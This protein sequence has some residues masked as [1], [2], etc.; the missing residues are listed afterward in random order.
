[1]S[2]TW[3]Y[4]RH[5][6]FIKEMEMHKKIYNACDIYLTN[7]ILK[8]CMKEHAHLTA[9]TFQQYD[10]KQTKKSTCFA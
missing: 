6:S 1:M 10:K 7:E 3:K 2:D 5:S 9:M 4:Q 8:N